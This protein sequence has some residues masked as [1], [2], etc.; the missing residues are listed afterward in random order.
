VTSRP[1]GRLAAALAAVALLG[2]AVAVWTSAP[3]SETGSAVLRDLD[4]RR[5]AL[6]EAPD[7]AGAAV[8]D[9]GGRF[10]APRQGLDVPLLSM[11]VS[12]GT[13]VPPTLTDAFLVRD[14]A[15]PG[16]PGTTIVTMHAVAGGNAP[17]NA[18]VTA[19][20]PDPTVTIEAGDP[21]LVDGVAYTVAGAEVLDKRAVT[22]A[23]SV[24]GEADDGADRLVVLTC[25]QRG[26]AGPAA[27]NLVV[28]ATR[29]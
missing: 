24:W 6:D 15:T 21:L 8:Q 1:R 9:T 27:E 26:G 10:V 3:G 7:L 20:R 18:L 14:R 19:G 13:L 12:G 2:A 29:D 4:G 22:T 25:V 17:G 16:A 28:H 11:A 23:P 5:V